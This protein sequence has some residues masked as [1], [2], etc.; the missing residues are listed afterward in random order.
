MQHHSVFMV[1]QHFVLRYGA[2][3]LGKGV[4]MLPSSFVIAFVIL[5]P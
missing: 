4:F 1:A 3:A 5:S 2:F